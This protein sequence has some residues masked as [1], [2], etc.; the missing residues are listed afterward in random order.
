MPSSIKRSSEPTIE[1]KFV[2][3]EQAF[4][5]NPEILKTSHRIVL[6]KLLRGSFRSRS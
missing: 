2:A 4:A 3:K 5:R 6:G 1:E